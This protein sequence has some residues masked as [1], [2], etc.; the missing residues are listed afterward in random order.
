MRRTVIALLLVVTGTAATAQTPPKATPK[1]VAPKQA[2]QDGKCV[3]VVSAIGDSLK[4]VKVGFTVFNNDQSKV[5]IDS[6]GI[7]D[8]VFN[9]VSAVHGKRF[10]VKRVSVAKGAFGVIEE[11]HHPFYEPTEDITAVVRKVTTPTRCDRYIVVTK[12]TVFIKAGL[13]IDGLGI[14]T[15]R[16]QYSAGAHYT[17]NIYD[18]RNFS[19]LSKHP[20]SIGKNYLGFPAAPVEKVDE[21]WWPAAPA[22]AATNPKI[23]DGFR[24]LVQKALDVTVPQLLSD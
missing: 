6:W 9:K 19:V 24:A 2:V 1:Q 21:S 3:G 4:L 20:P 22:D 7:D 16:F 23:R 5:P 18:G 13:R 14:L 11:D 12:T 8:L 15:E 17:M 10:N